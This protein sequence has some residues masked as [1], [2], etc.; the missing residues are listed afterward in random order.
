MMAL[1]GGCDIASAVAT[2][3]SPAAPQGR[4]KNEIAHDSFT[5]EV[6]AH[7]ATNAAAVSLRWRAIPGQPTR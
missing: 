7:G 2:R 4:A 5:P 3:T 6:A 1:G